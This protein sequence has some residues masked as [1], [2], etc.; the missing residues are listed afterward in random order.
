MLLLSSIAV[1][2][3]QR[4]SFVG[5]PTQDGSEAT[6]DATGMDLLQSAVAAE[7]QKLATKDGAKNPEMEMMITDQMVGGGKLYQITGSWIKKFNQWVGCRVDCSS[8]CGVGGCAGGFTG[9]F[10]ALHV[11][12]A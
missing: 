6:L 12:P 4:S 7:V 1:L 11:W 3:V 5:L 10:R 9:C 2:S 8:A